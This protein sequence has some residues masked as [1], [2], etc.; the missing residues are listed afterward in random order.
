[1]R[2]VGEKLELKQLLFLRVYS[3]VLLAKKLRKNIEKCDRN[4]IPI[5]SRNDPSNK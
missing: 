2:K 4:P 1:M 5:H 3:P